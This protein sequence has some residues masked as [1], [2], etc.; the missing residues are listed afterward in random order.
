MGLVGMYI[1]VYNRIYI[2]FRLV[3][4]STPIY[5]KI[6]E[7]T[8][9]C[10]LLRPSDFP[11]IVCCVTRILTGHDCRLGSNRNHHRMSNLISSSIL[12]AGLKSCGMWCKHIQWDHMAP[13]CFYLHHVSNVIRLKIL[14]CFRKH[15]KTMAFFYRPA[16]KHIADP[17]ISGKIGRRVSLGALQ[18]CSKS[19]RIHKINWNRLELRS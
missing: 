10:F 4:W 12:A 8:W 11:N 17:T 1:Y 2:F 9:I 18:H 15:P 14:S 16:K 7:N 6:V 3:T 5:T 19:I 13:A